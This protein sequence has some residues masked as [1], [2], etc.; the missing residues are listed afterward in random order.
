MTNPVLETPS[1]ADMDYSTFVGLV[2][3]R[4][5]P[6][7]GIRTVQEVAVQ[8]RI[9]DH[10]RVLEIGSNTGF[11]SVNLALLTGASVLGI[12][13]NADSVAEATAYAQL[14]SL[15][16]RVRFQRG[17][18]CRLDQPDGAFD[19]VWVSNVPS[20]VA[21]KQAMLSETVRVLATGGTLIAVPIFYRRNPPPEIVAEVSKAIGTEVPVMTKADWRAHF[22]SLD[23]LEL[24]FEADFEYHLR[25][26]RDIEDYCDILMAKEHLLTYDSTARAEIR[27]RMRYFMNLFNENLSYAGFSILL[28]QKRVSS[29]EVEFF[30]SYPAVGPTTTRA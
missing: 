6:S 18:A 14:H 17:D 9:R 15:A 10:S 11:T 2:R 23:G 26:E 13:I 28:F 21:D 3:E 19:A 5:R 25:G 7:G 12:D 1:W 29:D 8:A 20:F 24:Y 22:E 30:V 27:S 16:D 4:N